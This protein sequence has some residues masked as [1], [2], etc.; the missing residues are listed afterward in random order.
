MVEFDPR[1][2]TI[3][4]DVPNDLADALEPLETMRER[5]TAGLAS[6]PERLRLLHGDVRP[7]PVDHSPALIELQRDALTDTS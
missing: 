5:C 3:I 4:V 6:L 7:Y 2:A 1:T